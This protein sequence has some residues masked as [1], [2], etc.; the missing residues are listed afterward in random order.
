MRDPEGSLCFTIDILKW[1]EV[2]EMDK[3]VKAQMEV[4]EFEAEDVITTS[5]ITAVSY[6]HLTL[7]TKA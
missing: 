2:C 6:T 1:K 3:Y 4:I 7:P 5:V